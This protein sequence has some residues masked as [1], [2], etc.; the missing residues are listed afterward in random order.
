MTPLDLAQIDH[1]EIIF[2][3]ALSAIPASPIPAP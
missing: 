3:A 2:S 1:A